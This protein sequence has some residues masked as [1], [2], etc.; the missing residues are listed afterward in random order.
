GGMT[1]DVPLPPPVVERIVERAEGIPLFVE[2]LTKMVIESDLVEEREGRYQLTGPLTDLAIP[3][4]L[5]DSL[6]ARLDKLEGGK[7]VAQIGAALGREFFYELLRI[8]SPLEDP[9]L[10]EGLS[11]LLDA[12]LLYQRGV[13][14]EATYT[15]KHAMI[16]DIAY[17]SLLKSARRQFHERIAQVLEQ[18]FPERVES[19]PEVIARHADEAG[20]TREAIAHYQRA[21]QRA[22]EQSANEEAIVLL[23]RALELVGGLPQSADRLGQELALQ[24]AIATPLGAA[25]GW[26]DPE[27]E[28]AFSRAR[29][30]VSEI[31]EVPELPRVLTGLAVSFSAKGDLPASAELANQALEAAERTKDPTDLLMAHYTVGNPLYWQ[32]EV[33][34]ALDHFDQAIRLD[35]PGAAA[36]RAQDAGIE[37]GVLSRAFAAWCHW[38]LGY[39]E[40]ALATV[41]QAVALAEKSDHPIGLAQSLSNRIGVHALRREFGRARELSDEA[42][43]QAERHGFPLFAGI[44]RATR[45]WASTLSGEGE[46]GVAEIHRGMGGLAQ[47]G[48]GVGAPT[49]LSLLAEASWRAGQHDEGLA[50]IDA[51]LARAEEAGEHLWD[52]E[53]FRLRGE[54]LL[55]QDEARVEEADHLFRQSVEIAR[56]Q[57]ARGWELRG[58][59]SLARLWQRQSRHTEAR[60]LLRPVYFEFTEGL[61]TQDLLD[62]RSLLAELS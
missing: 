7:A 20:L 55:D 1:R 32:G 19:E 46:A 8:V 25:R 23:K 47:I 41:E 37:W 6:M 33:S 21:G 10:H 24:M 52:A 27:C 9:G 61:E 35:D 2:E 29:E 42:I 38:I 4:T 17:Q 56:R 40:R 14:P 60:D 59:T 18:Q 28:G 26:S 5:Q 3:A 45:G 53:L 62:A 31:G 22:I 15:F 43:E 51:A 44:A 16:Q 12:E 49:L 57:R 58:A 36:S 11:L 48:M 34:R 13:P 30:L 54:I 50:V 39:P